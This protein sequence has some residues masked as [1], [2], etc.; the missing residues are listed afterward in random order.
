MSEN[1]QN[2]NDLLDEHLRQ[3]FW[4]EVPVCML[5][6]NGFILLDFG[7]EFHCSDERLNEIWKVGARTVHPNMQEYCGTVLNGIVWCG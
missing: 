1:A 7:C 5:K 4:R 2:A 6:K 3:A